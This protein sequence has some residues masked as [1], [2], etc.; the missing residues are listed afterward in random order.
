ME[1]KIFGPR[2][3]VEVLEEKYEGL[4]IIIS[5]SMNI[6]HKI[7][8]VIAVGNGRNPDGSET[9]VSFLNEGDILMFQANDVMMANSN[10]VFDGKN[11]LAL[12]VNEMI[13][14]VE[15]DVVT[16]DTFHILGKWV[17]LEGHIVPTMETSLVLPE[18]D[19][20]QMTQTAWVR[21][22]VKQVGQT[23]ANDLPIEPGDELI[24]DRTRINSIKIGMEE[25]FY[26]PLESILG[27]VE[28]SD[29]LERVAE[30]NR[31]VQPVTS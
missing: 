18:Q 1:H 13:A 23:A 25:R 8:R 19:T 7:G 29:L 26:V 5:Q 3:F 22:S 31:I 11:C 28:G 2:V 21:F 20:Q 12:H 9:D 24:L 6:N 4:Q 30:A 16:E 15:S 14:K 17:L 10:Y 27:K